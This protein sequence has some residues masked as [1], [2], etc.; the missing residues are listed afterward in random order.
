V[1]TD[2][3]ERSGK[4]D[5]GEHPMTNAEVLAAQLEA[6]ASDH[7]DLNDMA[8]QTMREAAEVLRTAGKMAGAFDTLRQDARVRP[9]DES[10][11]AVFRDRRMVGRLS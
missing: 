8:R 3:Y 5:K 2:D 6:I 4:C 7:H 1:G 9:A 11:R 10:R